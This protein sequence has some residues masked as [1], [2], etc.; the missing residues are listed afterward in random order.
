VSYLPSLLSIGEV[1]KIIAKEVSRELS[2]TG[3]LCSQSFKMFNAAENT[4]EDIIINKTP[5]NGCAKLKLSMLRQ[6]PAF[7]IHTSLSI[8]EETRGQRQILSYEQAIN[9]DTPVTPL[10]TPKT[11]SKPS[12]VDSSGRI[13]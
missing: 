2:D 11:R 3:A 13:A 9:G 8:L 7:P 12:R 1:K 4:P 10:D 6:K 5:S